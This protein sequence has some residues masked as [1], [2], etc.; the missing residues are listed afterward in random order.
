MNK[1]LLLTIHVCAAL[2]LTLTFNACEKKGPMEKAGENIDEA[3]EN[4]SD[5]VKD[6]T[7]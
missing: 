7:N 5:D 1:K 2:L 6:A 4:V 3:A